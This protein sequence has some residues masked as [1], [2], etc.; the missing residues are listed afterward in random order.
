EALHRQAANGELADAYARLDACGADAELVRLAKAC[1]AP[2]REERPAGAGAVAEAIVAY[3]ARA[4][5]RL[6]QAGG[7]RAEPQGRAREERTRRRLASA[8]AAA[9]LVGLV[10]LAIGAVLLARK[11]QQLIAANGQLDMART[12]AV[13]KGDEAARARDRTFQAL[14]AMT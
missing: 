13:K 5:E 3:Q 11:N 6:R 12:E 1:L 10:G 4:E 9:V 2:N 8:L 7:E 14:D